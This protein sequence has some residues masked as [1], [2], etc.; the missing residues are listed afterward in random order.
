MTN[1]AAHENTPLLLAHYKKQPFRGTTA[2]CY[3]FFDFFLRNNNHSRTTAAT[4]M[5][6]HKIP[7]GNPVPPVSPPPSCQ[8]RIK[9][10]KHTLNAH[11]AIHI[12]VHR[13]RIRVG[14]P[15]LFT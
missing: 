7:I 8:M 5:P 12:L 11:L 15:R 14:T 4:A 1:R 9:N 3:A 10:I 2:F 6:P 13:L